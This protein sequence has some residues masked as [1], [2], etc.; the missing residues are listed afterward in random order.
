MDLH[1]GKKTRSG[2]AWGCVGL[3]NPGTLSEMQF[4][5]LT[6][7]F[8]NS[9]FCLVFYP[10]FQCCGSGMFIP[11]PDPT[12][13]HPGSDIFPSRIQTVSIP[14]PGSASTN[15]S[16]LTPKKNKKWFLS[17]RKYDPGS[18]SRIRMLT[19]YPSRIPVPGVKKTPDPGSGSATLLMFPFYKMLFMN[20]CRL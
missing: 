14:D 12:F 6:R 19:F 18:S 8:S 17:S 16:I 20:T 1:R 7:A 5:A 13:F 2:S 3:D 11:D 4:W 10:N 9:N 15:L